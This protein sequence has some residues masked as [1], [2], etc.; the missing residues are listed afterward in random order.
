MPIFLSIVAGAIVLHYTV[1][2]LIE[3]NRRKRFR[4]L[5]ADMYSEMDD[6]TM[7][8]TLVDAAH[9]EDVALARA[10]LIRLTTKPASG[11]DEWPSEIE[12]SYERET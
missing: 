3:W 1:G 5:V 8:I 10:G 12:V 7:V 6:G 4:S 2:V 11:D 9:P